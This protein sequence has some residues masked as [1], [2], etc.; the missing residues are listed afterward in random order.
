[1]SEP[2]PTNSSPKMTDHRLET[3][4][5]RLLQVGVALAVAIVVCGGAAYLIAHRNELAD[6]AVFV[7]EPAELESLSG[8]LAL[9]AGFDP[10]G[11]IQFGILVLIA[12]PIARVVFSIYAFELER[13]RLYV[14][15]TLIVLALL[16]VGIMT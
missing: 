14:A 6:R 1:M 3:I 16:T 5:G 9:A 10:G 13:D 7:G 11:V 8:I 4:I 12:T 15:I 2:K